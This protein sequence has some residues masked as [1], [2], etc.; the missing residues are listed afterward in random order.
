MWLQPRQNG[1]NP[2][3]AEKTNQSTVIEENE[4]VGW[5]GL[6]GGGSGN[7][8]TEQKNKLICVAPLTVAGF[9]V[10]S[11]EALQLSRNIVARWLDS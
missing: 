7:G 9:L 11:V 4:V 6:G 2:W 1:G 10:V 5:V 8:T 3:S